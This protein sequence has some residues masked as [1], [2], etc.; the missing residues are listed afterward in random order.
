MGAESMLRFR[1]GLS[2]DQVAFV[3]L[4]TLLVA[5]ALLAFAAILAGAMA[6]SSPV[7]GPFMGPFRWWPDAGFMG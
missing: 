5:L 1:C 7:E 4:A 6:G 3:I 2:R